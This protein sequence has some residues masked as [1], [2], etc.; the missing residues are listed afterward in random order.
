MHISFFFLKILSCA[1]FFFFP[2][3]LCFSL[4]LSHSFCFYRHV[5]AIQS[6]IVR[7]GCYCYC[8]TLRFIHSSFVYIAIRPKLLSFSTTIMFIHVCI[9]IK[10][11][12]TLYWSAHCSIFLKLFCSI[13]KESNNND[14]NNEQIS[15]RP[16]CLVF[17][18]LI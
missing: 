15:F 14:N 11:Y 10:L 16:L 12:W 13:W 2:F 4:A 8:I 9:P 5:S 17:S 7:F 18:H 3:H 6:K 1:L